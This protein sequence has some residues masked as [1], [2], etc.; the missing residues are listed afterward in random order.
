[1]V[2]LLFSTSYDSSAWVYLLQFSLSL[3]SISF[4]WLHSV[5][6]THSSA[7]AFVVCLCSHELY[8]LNSMGTISCG[9]TTI[10]V[11]VHFDNLSA[12]SLPVISLWLLNYCKVTVLPVASATRAQWQLNSSPE[13]VGDFARA[14][15]T[16]CLSVCMIIWNLLPFC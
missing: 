14:F 9:T 8:S 15:N 11:A 3:V 7:W 12:I 1:M 10:S 16:A 5:K 13:V 6:M 2:L 4:I